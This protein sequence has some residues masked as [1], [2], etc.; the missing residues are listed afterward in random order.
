MINFDED[1]G[2]EKNPTD[3]A[4]PDLSNGDDDTEEDVD[5]WELE[6]DIEE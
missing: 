6:E 3:D 2:L 4:D 5:S 1:K